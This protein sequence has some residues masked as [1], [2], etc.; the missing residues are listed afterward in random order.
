MPLPRLRLWQAVA[1]ALLIA[2]GAASAQRA[3][4][5]AFASP[6]AQSAY[7]QW[8]KLSQT[9]VDCVE[10]AL[11]ARRSRLW[12]VIQQ[13]IGPSDTAGARLL[14]ACRTNASAPNPSSTVQDRPGS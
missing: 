13:G 1:A 10:R 11:Q 12:N 8:R 3:D 4:P 5:R 2:C 7:A 6:K 9:E 14:A